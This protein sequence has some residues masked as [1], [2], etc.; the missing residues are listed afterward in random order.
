MKKL[1]GLFLASA[2]LLSLNVPSFAAETHEITSS[3]YPAYIDNDNTG[4]EFT[5]YFTDGARDLPYIDADFFLEM[6]N[7]FLGNSSTGDTFTME[8][9]GP[10]LT[11]TRTNSMISASGPVTIDFENDTIEFSDYNLFVQKPGSSTILDTVDLVNCNENGEP[12]LLEKVDTGAFTRYGHALVFPLIDYGID[13]ITQDGL[14]LIPLQTISDLFLAPRNLGDFY[15]N[16]KAVIKSTNVQDC[17]DLYYAAPTGERSEALTK[18]GYGELCMMLDFFYGFK[19]THNIESFDQ[20]FHDVG[21]EESLKGSDVL[22]ADLCINRLI[23]DFLSDGH[24]GWHAYSYLAGKGDYKGTDAAK[25]KLFEHKTRQEDAR[26]KFYPDSIPGYEE[27]GNTAYITFDHFVNLSPNG[28]DYYSVEDP[29]EFG[30]ED[31]IGLIIKAH[32]MINREDS[33]I[34]NVVLDLS[35]NT[36]GNDNA[37]VCVISWFLGDASLSQTDNMTGAMCTSV[38][39]A[40]INRDRQFDEKDT[41]SDKKLF[42]LIS[43]CSFSCGNLVPCVFKESGKVTLLGRT[44]GG[45]SCSVLFSS[46]AWGT[47]FQISS[48][49]RMSFL[50]NG[51]FYDVD[52]GAEPDYVLTSPESYYDRAALTDYINSLP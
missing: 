40:D 44:S 29:A 13:L 37:A 23:S 34:E 45:G 42:C 51:S 7:V 28:E 36:G 22:E 26:A 31:T 41:V 19:D 16:G 32:A 11:I 18:F 33:P 5:L 6:L 2:M 15:F 35:A 8:K 9:E 52:R 25:T 14:Y 1:L 43:P 20:L 30:D 21:F 47:S 38:Y 49:Q 27:V 48:N 4:M 3:N 10:V 50:K 24:S 17:S 39:K 12:A 46:S